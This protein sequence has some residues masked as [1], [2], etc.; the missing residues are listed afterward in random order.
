MKTYYLKINFNEL[1][2]ILL[3]N[4]WVMCS[5]TF[6]IRPIIVINF[7]FGLDDDETVIYI[8]QR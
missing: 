2:T 6:K 4:E 8:L 1:H 3:S 7:T 5:V